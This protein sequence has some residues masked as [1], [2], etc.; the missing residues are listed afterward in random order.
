MGKKDTKGGKKSKKGKKK[1][2]QSSDGNEDKMTFAEAL[3]AYQIKIKESE[4]GELTAECKL[5]EEKNARYKERNERLKGEQL[6]HIKD[7][8]REAKAQEKELAKKEIVNR[9]QVDLEIKEKWDYIREKEKLLE[10]LLSEINRLEKETV[11]KLL[12]RDYVLQY[13]NVGNE[14]HAKQIHRL[15]QERSSMEQ[16]FNEVNDFFKKNLEMVKVDIVRKKEKLTDETREMA[17]EDAVKNI[18][19]DSRNE[20]KEN[21]WLK[22]EVAVYRKDVHDLEGMIYKIEQE[23]LRMFTLLFEC[24]QSDLK[25]AR[26]TF[27]NCTLGIQED[28]LLTRDFVN[29]EPELESDPLEGVERKVFSMDRPSEDDA[30]SPGLLQILYEDEKDYQEYL[31]LGIVE[32]K[33][34]RIQGHAVPIH[35]QDELMETLQQENPGAQTRPQWP[36]TP[37]IINSA[38]S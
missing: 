25:V 12:H 22:K 38:M 19:K 17:A 36:V 1:K 34:L 8:V 21:D 10:E 2:K 23:N 15:Q 18:D 29:L 33:L 3:L 30:C 6:G 14:E 16:G 35:L 24:R 31:Q 13:K 20:I 11:E 4:L 9:E 26:N 5:V 27:L 37:K 32:R 28:G 7:L